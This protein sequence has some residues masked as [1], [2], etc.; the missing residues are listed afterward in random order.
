MW[1]RCHI[2][3][4]GDFEARVIEGTHSGF[5]SRSWTLDVHIKVLDTIFFGGLSC[6][7]GCDLS[8]K[9]GAF[10]GSTKTGATRG[11]PG[12]GI[13]LSISDRDDGVVEGG[14]HMGNPIGDLPL[15]LLFDVTS[16]F[17]HQLCSRRW[18]EAAISA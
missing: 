11:G 17:S 18:L 6:T 13:A 8:G 7:I 2:L 14:M 9:G 4:A 16:R 5:T 15:N 3:D 10:A 12:Q 1:D